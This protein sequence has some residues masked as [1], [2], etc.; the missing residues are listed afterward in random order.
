MEFQECNQISSK[1]VDLNQQQEQLVS[2]TVLPLKYKTVNIIPG[3]ASAQTVE[4]EAEQIPQSKPNKSNGQIPP[5]A[6]INE[7]RSM[8]ANQHCSS[9]SLKKSL[10]TLN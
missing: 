8:N 3:I 9:F 5:H 2:I 6:T 10:T 1:Q 7:I 4:T